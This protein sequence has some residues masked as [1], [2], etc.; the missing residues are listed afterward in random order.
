MVQTLAGLLEVGMVY[1]EG[2]VHSQVGD[3]GVHSMSNSGNLA[4]SSLVGGKVTLANSKFASDTI[5]NGDVRSD[6][7]TVIVTLGVTPWSFAE[8]N[9]V[10]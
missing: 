8:Y 10:K 2:W 1:I 7:G 3:G 9:V 5:S 4:V 6:W